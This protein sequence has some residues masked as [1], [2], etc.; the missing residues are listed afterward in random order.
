MH[1]A[2]HK[3]RNTR[4]LLNRL[5]LFHKIYEKHNNDSAYFP[6]LWGKRKEFR[7]LQP[8]IYIL[9]VLYF[10]RE[11]IHFTQL[12][13]KRQI[14]NQFI[15][16]HSALPLNSSHAHRTVFLFGYFGCVQVRSG[17]W[18]FKL[19]IHLLEIVLAED[20]NELKITL[21]NQMNRK[22]NL[23]LFV[24]KIL[25]SELISPL[26]FIQFCFPIGILMCT[27]GH[28]CLFVRVSYCES[29]IIFIVLATLA[30]SEN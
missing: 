12:L 23:T 8:Y 25:N 11:F 29:V 14:L 16:D 20:L 28:A 19:K 27:R 22:P 2:P 26:S 21:E 6:N 30:H 13:D 1:R 24:I 5:L 17:V 10:F 4:I 15:A 18:L 7:W 3:T 9:E